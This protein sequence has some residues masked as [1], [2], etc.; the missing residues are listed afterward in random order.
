MPVLRWRPLDRLDHD[1]LPAPL[2]HLRQLRR[3]PHLDAP[4]LQILAPVVVEVPEVRKHHHRRR[5]A[6]DALVVRRI[7]HAVRRT[8]AQPLEND[9]RHL[10]RVV[11]RAQEQRDHRQRHRVR[12]LVAEREQ[13]HQELDWQKREEDLAG[14]HDVQHAREAL[15]LLLVALEQLGGVDV[16]PKGVALAERDVQ[17]DGVGGVALAR[18]HGEGV[19]E[20]VG[21]ALHAL[22]QPGGAV[23]ALVERN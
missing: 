15:D 7:P 21:A 5:V 12:E 6:R 19:V 9:A 1:T 14:A 2:D 13:L 20:D 22:V 3:Q 18:E 8:G 11:A 16:G 23:L 10:R 17:L 4:A